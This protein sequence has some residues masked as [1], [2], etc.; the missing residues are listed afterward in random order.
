[1]EEGKSVTGVYKNTIG[2]KIESFTITTTEGVILEREIDYVAYQSSNISNPTGVITFKLTNGGEVSYNVVFDIG[3]DETATSIEDDLRVIR[4]TAKLNEDGSITLKKADGKDAVGVYVTTKTGATVE[5]KEAT[6]VFADRTDAYVAYTNKNTSDPKGVMVVTAKDGTVTEYPVTFELGLGEG[7]TEPDEYNVIEDLRVIRG[8]AALEDDNTIRLT[9]AAG[10]NAVG[11]YTTTK[12]KYTVEFK[13]IVGVYDE[14]ERTDALVA[15]KHLN[16]SNMT[17]TMVITTS[18]GTT[19][20]YKV[21]FDMGLGDVTEEP[22]KPEYDVVSDL[23]AIRGT[24]SAADNTVTITVASG[25]TATGI[26][27]TTKSG[28]RVEIKD[29]N[30]VFDASRT[31]AYVAYKD[32]NTANVEGT[33]VVT[34]A[35][36]TVYE[37]AVIFDLGL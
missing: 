12:S 8:T 37:Y 36:G 15:Y 18:D 7:T 10:K 14:T 9:V 29:A 32:K 28:A 20:E 13:D 34:L 26:Y 17:A 35:D 21:V 11:L 23:R 6:G 16:T 33:M 22:E 25:K 2:D 27:N 4:G 3:L 1:M 24:V 5:I 19:Y 31:D 30:G